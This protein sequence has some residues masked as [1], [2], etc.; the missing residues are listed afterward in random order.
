MSKSK[1]CSLNNSLIRIA[2]KL[3]GIEKEQSSTLIGLQNEFK[4]LKLKVSKIEPTV[5]KKVLEKVDLKT[6][7]S[8]K[9]NI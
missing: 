6:D 7:K 2:E 4:M 1:L 5:Y 8:D 3:R 9:I